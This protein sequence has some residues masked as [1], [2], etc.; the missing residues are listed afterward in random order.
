MF[1]S[2]WEWLRAL[3]EDGDQHQRDLTKHDERN[4][5]ISNYQQN[6]GQRSPATAQ[7]IAQEIARF[8]KAGVLIKQGILMMHPMCRA[9]WENLKLESTWQGSKIKTIR[10]NT[11]QYGQ[12]RSMLVNIWEHW[13]WF[14][15]PIISWQSWKFALNIGSFV[16]IL[17]RYERF[18]IF[19]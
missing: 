15:C 1:H 14:T 5:S 12:Y 9:A 10:C 3:V 18:F 6:L 19:P 8:T 4:S 17:A 11:M 7:W 13:K 16:K 2:G